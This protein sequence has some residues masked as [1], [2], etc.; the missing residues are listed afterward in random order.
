MSG[1]A[2][3]LP[4]QLIVFNQPS[5]LQTNN[6]STGISAPPLKPGVVALPR[7]PP[8]VAMANTD[9]VTSVGKWESWQKTVPAVTVWRCK[10]PHL[11]QSWRKCLSNNSF[12]PFL[13]T[14]S[15]TCLQKV[16]HRSE[17]VQ[18]KLW[19]TMIYVKG[20]DFF[21]PCWSKPG[22]PLGACRSNATRH[23]SL[24]TRCRDS[25][26]DNLILI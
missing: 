19:S 22:S 26:V 9:L 2:T 8:P 1:A 4:S 15:W 20:C 3:Y 25:H 21:R 16:I 10:F 7:P 23:S 11:H 12:A 6:V 13:S 18:K 14:K 24:H 5:Y 17:P